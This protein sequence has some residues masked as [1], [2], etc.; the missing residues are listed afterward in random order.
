[1]IAQPPTKKANWRAGV[2]IATE[3]PSF[4]SCSLGE[5]H[6]SFFFH[7]F[8]LRLF[9]FFFLPLCQSKPRPVEPRS[10][11]PSRKKLDGKAGKE[12]GDKQPVAYCS[13]HPSACSTLCSRRPQTIAVLLASSALQ[14]PLPYHNST[15]NIGMP[16]HF[17]CPLRI[18]GFFFNVPPL[19]LICTTFCFSC[20]IG[21][22]YYP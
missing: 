15:L 16:F 9:F 11:T 2:A 18:M 7:T 17:S 20:N 5:K 14:V 12:R 4:V 21:C 8:S 13:H 19:H 6:S 10:R 22:S 1:M 3:Q